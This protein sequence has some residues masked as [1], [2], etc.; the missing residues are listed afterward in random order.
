MLL[1]PVAVGAGEEVVEERTVV[2]VEAEEGGLVEVVIGVMVGVGVGVGVG[3]ELAGIEEM[4][5]PG[6]EETEEPGGRL[7]ELEA[8]QSVANRRWV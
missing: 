2:G 3:V 5:L 4:L 6:T 8:E 1:P 7:T